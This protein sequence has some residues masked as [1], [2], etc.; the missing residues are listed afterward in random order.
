[1]AV[2]VERWR[3]INPA[4]GTFYQFPN[5]PREMSEVFP[6]RNITAMTT[7]ALNG[8]PLLWEGAVAPWEWTFSGDIL[9]RAHYEAMQTWFY[10]RSIGTFQIRDH[11]GRVF[12]V[13]PLQ[14]KPKP[15]TTVGMY[16]RSTYDCRVLVLGMPTTATVGEKWS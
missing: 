10:T 12:N 7:A 6:Q 11:Y 14:F 15:K 3:F 1:M 4:N 9:T 16:W 8:Q 5:N 2:T 13:S